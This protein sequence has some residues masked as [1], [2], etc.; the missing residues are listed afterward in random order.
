M[1]TKEFEKLITGSDAT[2]GEI[3]EIFYSDGNVVEG[4]VQN[5]S[6]NSEPPFVN[7]CKRPV[8]K[9]Q[10]SNH[11]VRFDRIIKLIVKPINQEPKV[12]E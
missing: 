4:F 8:I 5:V 7:L 11:T 9:G 3:L 2:K 10:N 6:Y 12:Y 1:D